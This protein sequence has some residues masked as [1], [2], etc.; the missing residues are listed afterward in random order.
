[1]KAWRCWL[2]GNLTRGR[3]AKPDVRL[4]IRNLTREVVLAG[5]VEVADR[6][7]TRRK[8]LLGRDGLSAGEGL[9]ILP[10]EAVHTFGMRFP[11]DLVY[12]DRKHQVKKVR[13]DVPPWRLSACLSAHS[14]LELASGTIRRTETRPGDRLEFAAADDQRTAAAAISTRP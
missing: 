13:S 4:K 6:G 11:I 8:G 5:G 7:A 2:L 12:L 9:W 14:V 10:C 1:M 3:P